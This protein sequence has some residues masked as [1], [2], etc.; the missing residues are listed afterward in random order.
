M[1]EFTGRSP[2]ILIVE[3]DPHGLSFMESSLSLSGFRVI[4]AR[5]VTEARNI[6]ERESCSS[7]WGILCDYR[8]PDGNGIEFLKW[9]REQDPNLAFLIITG[10]GEK[11]VVQSSITHGAFHY[12]EK[13]ITH[14]ALSEIMKDAVLHTERMR[15]SV[16]DRQGL[17]DLEQFDQRMNAIIPEELM[18]RVRIFY[19]PLH[20]VGGDFFITHSYSPGEWVLMAG[21]VSGHEIKSG[22][23]STYIQ[24]MFRGCLENGCRVQDFLE[25][26][27]KTLRKR[28]FSPSAD[29]EIISLS[30]STFYI[31]PAGEWIC[32]WNFGFTPCH[33]ISDQG[34]IQPCDIGKFPLGWMEDI[35]V[36]GIHVRIK[37]NAQLLVFTDGLVELSDE[38]EINTFSL[39]YGLMHDHKTIKNLPIRPKD[40]ILI[41]SYS[42]NPKTPLNSQYQPILSEHYAGT[43]VDHIDHLQSNWRRSLSFALEDRLGDRLYDLLI[44]I[45]E[46]MLNAFIHGCEKAPDKFAHLQISISP[47]KQRLRIVIDDPGRGHTFDLKKRLDEMGHKRAQHL[48]LGIIQHLSDE[49]HLENKGTSLV[50]DFEISPVS[51]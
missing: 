36:S 37:G 19:Q 41:L 23:V 26:A 9:I 47:D 4:S 2:G 1:L 14:R 16:K 30:C 40:D 18:N 28:G 27:N 17:Q 31:P 21:D 43:E 13:P 45:R 7:L 32:H 50:F 34:R 8:L 38:L 12:L 42:V 6:C 24:G 15:Q 48:G 29:R 46:G 51:A 33:V 49:F 5:S 35:D 10:Q 11:S 20:E 22:F 3:D 25:L 39:L 44:C